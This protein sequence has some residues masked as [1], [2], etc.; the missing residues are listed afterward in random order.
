MYFDAVLLIIRG[1]VLKI[2]VFVEFSF[3]RLNEKKKCI[4]NT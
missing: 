2:I 4:Y 1:C 3:Y